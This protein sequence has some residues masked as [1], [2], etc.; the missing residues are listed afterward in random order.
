LQSSWTLGKE[1]P[2]IVSAPVL[3]SDMGTNK[4][5]PLLVKNINEAQ[6]TINYVSSTALAEAVFVLSA[7]HCMMTIEIRSLNELY[8]YFI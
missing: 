2:K 3:G 7:N 1:L 4:H 5:D 6:I 8:T